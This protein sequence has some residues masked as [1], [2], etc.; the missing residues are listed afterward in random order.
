MYVTSVA[1]AE[2]RL[3]SF[4]SLNA[5]HAVLIASAGDEIEPLQEA[6]R[7]AKAASVAE[8][9]VAAGES[10]LEVLVATR[11]LQRWGLGVLRPT[12]NHNRLQEMCNC[13]CVC[14]FKRFGVFNVFC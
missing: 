5:C 10:R 12:L 8:E 13:L 6:L 11:A 3:T 4:R 9:D 14:C 2:R 7:Q 1:E